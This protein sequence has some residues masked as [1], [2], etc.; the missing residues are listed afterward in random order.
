MALSARIEP[1]TR[2]KIRSCTSRSRQFTFL[3]HQALATGAAAAACAGGGD[4]T[5]VQSASMVAEQLRRPFQ[6]ATMCPEAALSE[7]NE[8]P[9]VRS[10]PNVSENRALAIFGCS[11]RGIC[12]CAIAVQ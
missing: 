10:S 11:A 3:P 5:A 7:E 1:F 2:P 8:P 12:T 6:S 9:A 4:L